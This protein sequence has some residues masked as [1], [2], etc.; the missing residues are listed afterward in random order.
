[1]KQDTE[2]LLHKTGQAI[3]AADILLNGGEVEFAA[4]RAYYAM[5]YTAEALLA[6]QGHRFKSHGSVHGL[7]GQH[8]AKTA[9]LDPKY[10]RWLIR[11]FNKR[12]AGD[13][14]IRPNIARGCGGDDRTGTRVPRRRPP[15][16]RRAARVRG[17]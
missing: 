8:F 4:G 7:Y 17:P 10:H 5:L 11:A 6:E 16:P 2:D 3:H 9:L 14:G 13:Y 1:M 15:V 12:I